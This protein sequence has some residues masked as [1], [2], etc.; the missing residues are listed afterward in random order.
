MTINYTTLLGLAKPVTGTESGA[1]GDVVN[2]QITSLVEDAIA[3]AASIN[4]TSGNVTLTDNNGTADQA[5][6]AIL[7]VSGTP[8]TTRNIVAPST[9]KWYI[10]RNGS[11]DAVVIKGSATTGVTIPTGSDALVFWN[12]SDFEV[13]GMAGPTS[14]T[15]NAVV[16]YDG[17]TGKV[18]QNSSVTID[19]SNNM[20]GVVALT[21]TGVVTVPAGTNTAPAI[22]TA[23]D[24]NTGIY[25]PS[26]DT[27]AFTEGGVEAMRIDSSGNVG[28]GTNNP[29]DKFQVNTQDGVR[30]GAASA[31]SY[32]KIG[33]AITG[34]G[35]AQISFDRA[36][37]A[38]IFSKGN[39]G[40]SLLEFMR[41]DS[42]GNVGIGTN[43]PTYKLDVNGDAA[44]TGTARRI[45]G[46]MSSATHV[47]RLSFQTS[48]ANG[49]TSPFFLPSG[50]GNIASVIVAN[51]SDPTNCSFG[52]LVVVGTTDVRID[53]GV[54]GT[55]SYLPL[56][57]YTGGN[58][59]MRID[60]SGNLLVG[61]ASVPTNGFSGSGCATFAE[62][63]NVRGITSHAGIDG[64][65]QGHRYNIQW[66]G[67]AA[68]LW[69]DITDL[70]SIQTSSDYR[71][72]KDIQTQATD[73]L[74]RIAK[75]RPVTYTYADYEPFSWKADGVLREGFIAHELAE[76]IPSAVE[77]EKDAPNQIQSLKVD[78][79]CS[80][81]VKAI[82]EQQAII[83]QLTQRIAALEG[84]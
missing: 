65:Y 68:K 8:G 66:T 64:A 38:T 41:L 82:Q 80:V 35:T 37:G 83:E 67:A 2:D 76:V 26:A 3:N 58:E 5:R 24:S 1:W 69:V 15:D 72:K 70:G 33:S 14:S 55:G 43:S 16:R 78:A 73:A 62:Y 23:S 51:A 59:R 11:N 34:E 46:D 30:L 22:T 79:L 61:T 77:G 52:Q 28:I 53:S 32:V 17:T 47:N 21:T 48:V 49:E 56:T 10:V 42:N 74:S 81:L 54:L 13:G 18:V 50:S 63:I 27:I 9:S 19:D 60:S 12:G 71:V 20:T 36:A 31:V 57:F 4:V 7:L 39:T 6:M 25:F 44:I 84:A 40:S 75:I 29:T 45:I